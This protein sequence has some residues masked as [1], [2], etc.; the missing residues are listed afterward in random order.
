MYKVV[1]HG[2]LMSVEDDVRSVL[3][4]YLEEARTDLI[5][6][7]LLS[8]NSE[9]GVRRRALFHLQQASEK[10]AKNPRILRNAHYM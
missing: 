6:F 2:S 7:R 1:N 10:L 4:G 9:E 5:V 8:V 3:L